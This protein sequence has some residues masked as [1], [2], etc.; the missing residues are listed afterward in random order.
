MDSGTG[1]SESHRFHGVFAATTV[2]PLVCLVPN[3]TAVGGS[4]VRCSGDREQPVKEVVF[5]TTPPIFKGTDET[6]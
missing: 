6:S 4:P 1:G 3:P 5:G 2:P